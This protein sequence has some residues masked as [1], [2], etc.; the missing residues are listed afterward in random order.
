MKSYSLALVASFA[1]LLT[2]VVGFLIGVDYVA[3]EI[4]PL[5]SVLVPS[6]VVYCVVILNTITTR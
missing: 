3:V 4:G 2:F 1:I 5:L 6:V